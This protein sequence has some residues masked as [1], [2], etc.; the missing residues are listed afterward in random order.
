MKDGSAAEDCA[1]ADF[2]VARKQAIVGDDDLVTQLDVM[3]EVRTNHEITL[4][5]DNSRRPF[6]SPP[7]NG[8]VFAKRIAISNAHFADHRLTERKILGSRADNCAVADEISRPKSGPAF[9]DRVRLNNASRAKFDV[10][11]DDR[12]R[13]N[14]DIA[15]QLSLRGDNGRGVNFHKAPA[16]RKL[17]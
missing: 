8:H 17:K 2:H 9:E 12:M 3:A 10:F 13:A 4:V 15:G 6:L 16:S 11:P 7:M 5:S 1:V 14:L